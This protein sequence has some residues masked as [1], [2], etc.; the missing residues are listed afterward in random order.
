MA[1][2]SASTAPRVSSHDDEFR[3]DFVLGGTMTLHADGRDPQP[4]SAGDSFVVPA[5]TRHALAE[6]SEDF[7]LLEV[8]LP[9]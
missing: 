5:G 4:L 8:T 2:R 6:C 1:R 9:K 7:E 3:F